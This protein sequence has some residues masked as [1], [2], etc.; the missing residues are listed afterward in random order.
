MEHLE[1]CFN[2]AGFELSERKNQ[3]KL[4][5]LA[6]ILKVLVEIKYLDRRAQ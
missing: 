3:D 1:N 4:K 6:I 2:K 5:Y